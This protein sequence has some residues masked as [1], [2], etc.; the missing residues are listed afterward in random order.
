MR[1]LSYKF[2]AVVLLLSMSAFAADKKD[3]QK[4]IDDILAQPDNARAFWGIEVVSLDTG[5][6]IYS[7]NAE[8]LFTPASNTKLFTT[9]A[10]LALVGPN[11]TFLTTVETR[12]TVDKY[13]RLNGDLSL[14]GRGDPNLSGR[15]LPYNLKTERTLPP[16]HFLET[17]ADQVAAKGVKVIDGDV[18]G[19]DSYYAFQRYGEGWSQN[20]LIDQSGA[21]VSAL[22]IN[23]NVIFVSAMPADRPGEKAFVNI[24]P[25]A[26]Y[27][28]ID[29]RIITTPVGTGQREIFYNREPGSD[30]LTLWGSIPADDPGVGE[31]LAIDDPADFAARIFRA[32]LEKRGI[33]IY[34]RTKVKHTELASLSTFTITTMA[35]AAG[36]GNSDGPQRPTIPPPLVL[37]SYQSQPLGQDLR[38]V[39]KVSQNLHAELMLRMLGRERG[40]NGSVAAGLE[41][42]R[43]WLIQADIRPEEY[44][45]YDGSGLSR[46]NL[47]TPHAM[48]KLL[49]YASKQAWSQVFE[50]TLPVGGV[51]GTLTQRFKSSEFLGR[52]RGKTGNL[53]HVNSLS[54]Y[55][56]T[57]KGERIVFAVMVNNHNLPTKRALESIDQ[58]VEMVVQDAPEP[59]K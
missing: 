25:W 58:I 2:V 42:L 14:V 35:P 10:S 45:F 21:P 34:G 44:A 33:V 16:V 49:S 3:L 36:G 59:K 41:V 23:D 22:T 32:M 4:R 43:G 27:Y 47:V 52:V 53:S 18:V 9:A 26:D 17:L 30:Q 15:A 51:D 1:R 54:G 29:N 20:D 19:D 55:A 31:A 38:V 6:T 12:G 46:Q 8:K 24:T 5:K 39:N 11:H 57:I 13:G 56:T 50:D 28:H 7:E 48:V 40:T 37:A